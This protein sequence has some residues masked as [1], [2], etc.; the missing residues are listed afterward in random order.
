MLN[1]F[2]HHGLYRPRHARRG[3]D[4]GF[5]LNAFRHHGLYRQLAGR[6]CLDIVDVLNAFRHHGLYRSCPPR[7]GVRAVRMCS[8][9]FGITDYIGW[10]RRRPW[11][12][13]RVLNAFRHHGLYRLYRIAGFGRRRRKVLNAFRHHG[14]YRRRLDERLRRI[15]C[16]CSTPFGITDYIGPAGKWKGCGVL[17]CSTPFGITDYIGQRDRVLDK[18]RQIQVL[19]AFRHHGLYRS[20]AHRGGSGP[21][22]WSCAQR[23]SASR[24]ISVA[25]EYGRLDR[26]RECSTPF[27][28]TDYIGRSAIS[29]RMGRRD[30]LNAFRHHGLYRL[31]SCA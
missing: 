22:T 2:R 6:H 16:M 18:E 1:A 10:H 17:M 7:P 5:V 28:I 25:A 23:L 13:L 9:P 8:T 24:I 29:R 30:V 20:C 26:G 19:N 21:P 11:H 15:P 14:L 4:P 31:P 27:G 3:R 12:R